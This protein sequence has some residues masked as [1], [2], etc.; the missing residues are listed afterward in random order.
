[1]F[2]QTGDSVQ[3]DIQTQNLPEFYILSWTNDKSENIVVYIPATKVVIPHASYKDRVYFNDE[4]FSLTLKNT[5][6]TDS[7][8]YTA[9]MKRE[10]EKDI[11]TY[12]VSVKGECDFAWCFHI[13]RLIYVQ[14]FILDCCTIQVKFNVKMNIKYKNVFLFIIY[15]PT[16]QLHSVNIYRNLTALNRVMCDIVKK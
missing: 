4:T 3:L 8:L 11:V 14:S 5:Q 6:K 1:V 7:G 16:F 12:R 13:I 10:K 9:K 15:L 2:V